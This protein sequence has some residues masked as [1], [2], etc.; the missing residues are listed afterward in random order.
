[1]RITA[2]HITA[3]GNLQDLSLT[4][5]P[6]QVLLVMPNGG[7]KTTLAEFIFALLY[8]LGRGTGK[9]SR[10]SRY[11]PWNGAP[12]GGQMEVFCGRWGRSYRLEGYFGQRPSEDRLRLWDL[13]TGKEVAL[14]KVQLPGA[15]LTGLEAEVF[16]SL[17]LAVEG[18]MSPAAGR[19]HKN[20][21]GRFLSRFWQPEV[22][23]DQPAQSASLRADR[24]EMGV[25]AAEALQRIEKER[26]RLRSIRGDKGLIPDLEKELAEAEQ[27]LHQRKSRRQTYLTLQ[28]DRAKRLAELKSI[29]RQAFDTGGA[30]TG[31]KLAKTGAAATAN[32]GNQGYRYEGGESSLG[33]RSGPAILA[34]L[35]LCLALLGL[36]AGAAKLF[37]PLGARLPFSHAAGLVLLT[38]ALPVTLLAWWGLRSARRRGRPATTPVKVPEPP[39]GRDH[40][41]QR[42]MGLREA[43][44]RLDGQIEYLERI[45]SAVVVPPTT[46]AVDRLRSQLGELYQKDRILLAAAEALTDLAQTE[47]ADYFRPFKSDFLTDL[48]QLR[49]TGIK[50]ARLQP[51]FSLQL[52]LGKQGAPPFVEEEALSLH[53]REVVGLALRQTLV[54]ATNRHA[55]ISLPLILDEPFAGWDDNRKEAAWQSLAAGMRATKQQGAAGF[56]QVL[57][58]LAS[59]QE[60]ER[61]AA[62]AGGWTVISGSGATA[63]G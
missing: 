62:S 60:A 52:S 12:A 25:P 14:A 35:L 33:R 57:G 39:P 18:E 58:L 6:A 46:A 15:Y 29:D 49:A 27:A 13:S 16:R 9:Q 48:K 23:T 22:S 2:L 36:A 41:Q 4:Q 3:F 53:E 32:E 50:T 26:Q 51:D 37:L 19:D 5:I 44:A 1:M 45:D 55:G 38:L 28:K 7:G 34:G 8:G 47:Q 17:S 43:I 21:K 42:V 40:Q 59:E 63:L 54:A 20:T 11:L 56:G 10:R 61:L 31:E 30:F 24:G